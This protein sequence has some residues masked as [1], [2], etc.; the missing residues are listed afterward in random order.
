MRKK[1]PIPSILKDAEEVRRVFNEGGFERD[2]KLGLLIVEVADS[3]PAKDSSIRNWVPGTLS[4]N[5]YYLNKDGEILA[6][7]HR[8]LRPD[9]DLAASGKPDPKRVF[10]GE[11]YLVVGV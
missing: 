2:A 4:Q 3:R 6:K 11:C 1:L 7:A 5:V 8:Y 9:G 10:D